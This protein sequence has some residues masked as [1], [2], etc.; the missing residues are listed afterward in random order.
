MPSSADTESLMRSGLDTAVCVS[1]PC[2]H[3][4]SVSVLQPVLRVTGGSG[5]SRLSLGSG[6]SPLP[7]RLFVAWTAAG[8]LLCV[9]TWELSD[10][11]NEALDMNGLQMQIGST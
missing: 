4:L 7:P 11:I 1:A 6:I 8:A 9:V 10:G 3:K 5:T 2:P